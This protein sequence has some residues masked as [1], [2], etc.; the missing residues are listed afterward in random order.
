MLLKLKSIGWAARG[1]LERQP[2]ILQK[3][4]KQTELLIVESL[5]RTMPSATL[6]EWNRERPDVL[7][8]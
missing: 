6:Y 5:L 2:D 4:N 7:V 1:A 3:M 8:P